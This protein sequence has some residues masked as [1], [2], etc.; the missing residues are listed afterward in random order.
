LTSLRT[1]IAFSLPEVLW[2][3][4]KNALAVASAFAGVLKLSGMPFKAFRALRTCSFWADAGD[5][6][7][8]TIR[9][10]IT[11]TRRRMGTSDS[12]GVL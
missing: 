3:I 8:I 4:S 7:T 2:T 9:A 12:V 1:P 6:E 5:A 10:A 11:V